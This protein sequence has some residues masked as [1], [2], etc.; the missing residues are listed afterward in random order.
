VHTSHDKL[1]V[2]SGLEN[3]IVVNEGNVL[4]IFPKDQEQEIKR[5]RALV[6]EKGFDRFL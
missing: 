4:L 3:F 5:L 6:Q 2:A 1:T